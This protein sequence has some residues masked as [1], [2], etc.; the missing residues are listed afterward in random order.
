MAQC[1]ARAVTVD[2]VVGTRGVGNLGDAR[3]VSKER[4]SRDVW[5]Q[6]VERKGGLLEL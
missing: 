5:I 4:V 1:D 2:A 6:G 3:E